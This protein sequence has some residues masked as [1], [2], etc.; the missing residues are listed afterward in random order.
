MSTHKVKTVT[1]KS[2]Y[3]EAVLVLTDIRA[4][5]FGIQGVFT[6]DVE[7]LEFCKYLNAEKHQVDRQENEYCVYYLHW[8]EKHNF[9][10]LYAELNQHT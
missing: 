6:N 2:S 3:N 8:F 10:P 7:V 5:T 9:L 1:F 4:A